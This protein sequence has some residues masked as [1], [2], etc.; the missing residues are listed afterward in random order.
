ML[1]RDSTFACNCANG[2]SLVRKKTTLDCSKT[3]LAG[4]RSI[5]TQGR[6][7]EEDEEDAG[8]LHV[9]LIYERGDVSIAPSFGGN[10]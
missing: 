6:L 4:S 5:A 8:E 9:D 2:M 3:H 10:E 1:Q 7:D